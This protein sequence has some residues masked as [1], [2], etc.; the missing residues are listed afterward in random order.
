MLSCGWVSSALDGG[1][2]SGRGERRRD[3]TRSTTRPL[4]VSFK[5]RGVIAIS[6]LKLVSPCKPS[7]SWLI[8]IYS[9]IVNIYDQAID[10]SN[11]ALEVAEVLA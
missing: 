8:S 11:K 9:D 3:G 2:G 4:H 5:L 7:G 6:G 1:Q 10:A